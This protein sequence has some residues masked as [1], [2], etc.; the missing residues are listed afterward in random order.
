MK[1]VSAYRSFR[2]KCCHD[3]F[4]EPILASLNSEAVVRT[5]NPQVVC[6]CGKSYSNNEDEFVGVKRDSFTDLKIMGMADA[7]I[8]SFLD[9]T[10]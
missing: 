8:P 2:T 4:Y 10:K 5:T 7:D 9:K 6:E 1:S 3:I